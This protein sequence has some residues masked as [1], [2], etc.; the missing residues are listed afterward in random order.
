MIR[1]LHRVLLE[2]PAGGQPLIERLEGL[3]E[4]LL[5]VPVGADKETRPLLSRINAVVMLHE[6]ASWTLRAA[7]YLISAAGV[8]AGGIMAIREAWR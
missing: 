7:V 5:E 3:C 1:D 2:A 4:A 6:R 8:I